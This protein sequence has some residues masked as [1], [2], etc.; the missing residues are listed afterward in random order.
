MSNDVRNQMVE[1]MRKAC[2]AEPR[3]KEAW[4]ATCDFMS[5]MQDTKMLCTDEAAVAQINYCALHA[6]NMV[7]FLLHNEGEIKEPLTV[8]EGIMKIATLALMPY[9]PDYEVDNESKAGVN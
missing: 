7:F 4:D 9:V 8:I 1:L 2:A 3:S 6:V 5:M